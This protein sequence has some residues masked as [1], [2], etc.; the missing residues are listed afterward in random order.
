MEEITFQGDCE[1]CP[2]KDTPCRYHHFVPQRLL[3]I[4]PQRFA[5]KWKFMKVRICNSCNNYFHP[6]N[7]LYNRIE[8]LLNKIKE[9]EE[10]IRKLMGGE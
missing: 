8:F 9:L 4:L 5:E 7:S 2:R 1:I 3:K 6:E 10:K